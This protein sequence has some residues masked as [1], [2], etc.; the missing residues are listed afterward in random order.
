MMRHPDYKRLHI[1]QTPNGKSENWYCGTY[2]K[3]RFLRKTTGTP[4]LSDALRFA[5]DWY[6]D[7]RYEIK[8]GIIAEHAKPLRQFVPGTLARLRAS[9]SEGYCNSLELTLADNREL[10]S[11]FRDHA[12]DRITSSAWDEFRQHVTQSRAAAGSPALSEGTYHQ[13]KNALRLVLKQAQLEKAIADVPQFTDLLKQARK[14]TKPRVYFNPLEW[15]T[16]WRASLANIKEHEK[17]GSRW[18]ADAHELHDYL[19]FMVH[20]GLRVGESKKLVIKDVEI[21]SDGD[22]TEMCRVQVR[23]GKRGP[24][25]CYSFIRAPVAFRRIVRRRQIADPR[26]CSEPLFLKHHHEAFR[27]LLKRTGLYRDAFGNKR[28]FVSLRHTHICFALGRG[29]KI[30]DIAKNTRTSVQ[31]I[32]K[33]Y[34]ALLPPS[35]EALNQRAWLDLQVDKSQP[36]NRPFKVVD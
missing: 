13:W 6:E 10:M 9:R 5:A 21:V 36:D 23:Q 27:A 3:G 34:A 31:M 24:G 19:V 14:Q 29:V 32:E 1:F 12:V 7:R 8:H 28:D 4:V 17:T 33:H 25:I 22:R 16:L 20:T 15:E 35:S 18:I 11:F 30:Q 2:H 26:T